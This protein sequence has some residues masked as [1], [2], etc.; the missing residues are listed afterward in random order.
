M[1]LGTLNAAPLL[2]TTLNVTSTLSAADS[3]Q[4]VIGGQGAVT[5][6]AEAQRH[7]S[8]RTTQ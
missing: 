1:L 6:T 3:S 4:M 7:F 8:G 5:V 2:T